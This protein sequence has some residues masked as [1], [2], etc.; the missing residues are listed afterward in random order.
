MTFTQHMIPHH[1]QALEMAELVQSR[2][3]RPELVKLAGD[4]TNTQGDEISRMQRWL[5]R[6]GKPEGMTAMDHHQMAMPG[7]MD[8][9]EV[10]RFMG[11]EDAQFD[12]AFV[13]M[14]SRHHQGAI[15][16]ANT[17]APTVEPWYARR[18]D[19]TLYRLPSPLAW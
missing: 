10:G 2:T 3:T 8:H 14:M 7:M 17:E 18:R 12:V 11:L 1:R 15:V 19:T 6:W 13:D 16:M 5:Q 9:A 4:I